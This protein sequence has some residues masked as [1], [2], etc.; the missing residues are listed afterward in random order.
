MVEKL[1]S[2]ILKQAKRAYVTR[3]ASLEAAKTLCS[4]TLP[5]PGSLC[6][7]RVEKLGH[8]KRLEL[9]SGR[10]SRLF[11][12]DEIVVAYGHRYASDQFH[13][14]VPDNLDV[15]DLVAAGGIASKLSAKHDRARIPTRIKPL[16][17]LCDK[18][19]RVMNLRHWA[20]PKVATIQPSR[21]HMI[22][23]V[24]SGMN[25]GKTTTVSS[26]IRT[27]KKSGLKVAAI[28]ITGTGAGGDMWHYTDAGVDAAF[29]FTDA[30]YASTV[31]LSREELD[32]LALDLYNVAAG[33][34]DIVIA[35]LADGLFQ[36]ETATL[37]A[38]S[39]FQDLVNSIAFA[40]SDPMAAYAGVQYLRALRLNPAII[41]GAISAS[42]LASAEAQKVTSVPVLT[43]SQFED[44]ERAMGMI[45]RAARQ[46]PETLDARITAHI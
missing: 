44:D 2:Q 1:N 17:L 9:V 34:A 46:T 11:V 41:S 15:C 25:A 35:E 4:E 20:L 40:T 30:G 6:L 32:T 27:A 19:G 28:K 13:S 12:G 21:T 16:G 31:D 10:R 42:P 18:T 36:A 23:V 37:L 29:D 7:A 33:S 45:L 39:V 3:R 24:G 38:S 14:Y 5:R 26:I 43:L 8:H 22:T